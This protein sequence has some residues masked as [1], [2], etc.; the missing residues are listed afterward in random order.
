M[1]CNQIQVVTII[2]Y[3]DS[4][5]ELKHQVCTFTQSES[6]RVIIPEEFRKNKSIVAVCNGDVEILNKVG[7]RILP[8]E[9]VA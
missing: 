8:S 2:Y 9:F 5:L 4:S 3:C 7:E 1:S 6:G